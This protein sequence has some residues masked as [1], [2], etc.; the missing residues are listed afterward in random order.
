MTESFA[1]AVSVEAPANVPAGH[2]YA[3]LG[4]RAGA[5]AVGKGACSL[6]RIREGEKFLQRQVETGYVSQ[7]SW[8]YHVLG[9]ARPQRG[10]RAEA[11]RLGERAIDSAVR[12]PEEH[13]HLQASKWKAPG[14]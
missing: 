12:P 9:R 8:A 3:C 11:R 13:G 10:Q 14:V 5:D 7:C 1:V 2:P 4:V 6:D